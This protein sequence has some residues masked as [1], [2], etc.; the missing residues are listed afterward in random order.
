MRAILFASNSGIQRRP[1]VPV[2]IVKTRVCLGRGNSVIEPDVV[3]RPILEAHSSVNHRAPSGRTALPSEPASP[4]GHVNS[5]RTPDVVM[6]PILL[7]ER[8][9]NQRFPSGPVTIWFG[10]EFAA[11]PVNSVMLPVVVIRPILAVPPS[12]NHRAQ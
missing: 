12:V 7:A 4:V 5:F 9:V 2:V 8:S 1:S 11:G 6:R 3:M 10:E